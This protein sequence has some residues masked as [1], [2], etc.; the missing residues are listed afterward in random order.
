[1]KS[2]GDAIGVIFR[3]FVV[4]SEGG[5]VFNRRINVQIRLEIKLWLYDGTFFVYTIFCG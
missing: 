3:V 5:R 4:E 2:L 1:M